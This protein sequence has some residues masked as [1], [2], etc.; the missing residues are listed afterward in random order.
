[1]AHAEITWLVSFDLIA[2]VLKAVSFEVCK[3]LAV[4]FSGIRACPRLTLCLV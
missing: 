1:M 3:N 2:D 4:D